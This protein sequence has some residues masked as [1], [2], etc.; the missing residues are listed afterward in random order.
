MQRGRTVLAM[1]CV[2]A[3][4]EVH[5]GRP[6]NSAVRLQVNQHRVIGTTWLLGGA[7]LGLWLGADLL[8]VGA[9]SQFG[10][11][12]SF[13]EPSWWAFQF[14]FVAFL[15]ICAVI[16]AGAAG[17][18]R[19]GTIGLRIVG[20]IALLYLVA[21]NLLGGERAWWLALGALGLT[22]VV[23]ASVYLA[24]RGKGLAT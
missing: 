4:A 10:W 8:R 24:Y 9:D 18:R 14:G 20:P 12:T 11:R 6:L 2:L 1:N 3:G 19:W 7:A 5:C 23:A 16:G 22:V 21:Y 17:R 13:Y 15:G